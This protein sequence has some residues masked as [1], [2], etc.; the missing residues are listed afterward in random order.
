[1]ANLKV[2]FEIN[3]S[4]TKFNDIQSEQGKPVA[5]IGFELGASWLYL[6]VFE[7]TVSF[8]I[9]SWKFSFTTRYFP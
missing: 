4:E 5:A 8:I 7:F 3:I 6:W 1:V 9:R 2:L